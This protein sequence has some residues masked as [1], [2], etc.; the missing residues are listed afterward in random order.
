MGN[1]QENEALRDFREKD[2]DLDEYERFLLPS[3]WSKW[4]YGDEFF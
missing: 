1:T 4:N 2:F 3:I